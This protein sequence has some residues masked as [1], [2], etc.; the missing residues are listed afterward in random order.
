MLD[1]EKIPFTEHLDEL[2]KRLI[3]CFIAVGIGFLIA[4]GFKEKLFEILAHPLISVMKSGNKIIFTGLPEAFF[5]YMK[6]AFIAGIGLATPVIVYQFWMF[7]A[8]G[9]YEKERR[10]V[11]PVVF[12]TSI[13]FLGGALFGYFFVFPFG[14]VYL[15]SFASETILP[16]PSM[17]EYFGFASSMLLAF[18]VVF[19]LPL[20]ITFMARFGIVTVDFLRKNRKYAILIIFIVA[21]ILTPGPDVVSQLLM[22]AP[23]L[24]LY[25][26]SIIGAKIFGR[27]K[28][29]PDE[30]EE[31]DADPSE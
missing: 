9:L 8:P 15:M 6:V 19:E 1:D 21:A 14:F 3:T 2:R 10:F 5:V 22:A 23:L 13:F 26:I 25:E 16:M 11:F 7:V 24:V 17:N 27:K 18:G 28:L 20:V 4:F 30:V 31:E 12:L 29:S